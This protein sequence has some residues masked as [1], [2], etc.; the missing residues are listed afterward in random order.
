MDYG[1]GFLIFVVVAFL[2]SIFASMVNEPEMW[3]R[4]PVTRPEITSRH[5]NDTFLWSMWANQDE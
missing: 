4:H 2:F 5:D 1:S 3:E